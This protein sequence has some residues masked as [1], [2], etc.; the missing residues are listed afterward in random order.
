MT[1]KTMPIASRVPRLA[2]VA[3]MVSDPAR[4]RMLAFLMSGE[5][6]R[7]RAVPIFVWTGQN[8]ATISQTS[9]PTR[10]TS[11]FR[12]RAGCGAAAGVK[13]R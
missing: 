9:W 13:W 6:A 11:T 7:A 3:T 10:S 12:Q 4:S 1:L 5:Y 2:R 8:G